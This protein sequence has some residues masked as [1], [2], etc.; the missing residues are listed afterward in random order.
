MNR[1]TERPAGSPPAI[2]DDQL[3]T[4]VRASVDDW[5][6]P[7]QRLDQPTWRDRVGGR[8]AP[9]RRG[10][11][12]RLAGPAGAAVV[13]TVVVAF[14]AVWLTTPRTTP[15][16]AAVSP[17]ATAASSNPTAASPST[18]GTSPRPTVSPRPA[19]SGL[20]ALQLDGALPDP[21][22][23]M[24]RVDTTH[25]IANLSTGVLEDVSI[26]PHAGPTTLFPRPGG[27][28]A[29]ICGD[30][31]G[32]TAVRLTGLD[33]TF[34]SVAADGSPQPP[35][36]LRT[37]R[38]EL[39]PAYSGADQPELVDAGATGSADGRYA[40][41]GWVARKG[42][43]GWTAGIDVVDLSNGK[44]VDS[45]PLA[46]GEPKGAGGRPNTRIA[47]RVG[48]LAPAQDDI[49]ASLHTVPVPRVRKRNT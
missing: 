43:A 47:P 15:G 22:R 10:W 35:I 37:L 18:T 41:V 5:R 26:R 24:V 44:V 38:G 3:A 17:S 42:A 2:D 11:L 19:G 40:L 46:V 9:R 31:T 8:G 4:L 32:S 48:V 33:L 30:W 1:E 14:V 7:P 27:G 23:I 39:D 25:R 12:V 20:P 49:R 28:W 34:E 13:A 29:C 45:T 36:A 16:I 6:M 21:D